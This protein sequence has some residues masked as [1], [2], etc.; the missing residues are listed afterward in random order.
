MNETLE[1]NNLQLLE[2]T[3]KFRRFYQKRYA[4][5][6]DEIETPDYFADKVLKNYLYK[7]ADIERAVKKSLKKHDNFKKEI[8]KLPKTGEIVIQNS[9]YGEFALMAALVRKSLKITAVEP[10]LEKLEIARNCA[11]APENLIYTAILPTTVYS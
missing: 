9:G 11:S 10:D 6:A 2:T 7:G 1:N 4:E 5:I 3:K 8:E